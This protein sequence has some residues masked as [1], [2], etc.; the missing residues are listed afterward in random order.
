MQVD[1]SINIDVSVAR[2]VAVW[3]GVEVA[4][5]EQKKGRNNLKV[6]KK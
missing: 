1:D 5:P 4:V 6:I 3:L 2:M